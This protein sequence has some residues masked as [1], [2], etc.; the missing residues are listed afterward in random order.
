MNAGTTAS[1][2]ALNLQEAMERCSSGNK[3]RPEP[4]PFDIVEDSEEGRTRQQ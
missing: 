4:T 3:G 1:I 2:M